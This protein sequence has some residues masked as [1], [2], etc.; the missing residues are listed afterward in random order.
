MYRTRQPCR[1]LGELPGVEV[2]SG[3]LLAPA[4]HA[5]LL[6][7]D[8]LV[9]CDVVDADLLPVVEARRAAGRLTVYEVND[10]FLAP[11]PWNP[12]AYLARNLLSRSL[13]SQTAAR[14]D[15]V[16]FSG[17][18]LATEFARLHPRRVV[19]ENQLWAV[20]PLRPRTVKD[21]LWLGWGGS[22]GHLE[23]MR[24]VMPALR[25]ALSRHP[26]LGLAIMGA[27]ELAPLL[28]GLPPGRTRYRPGGSLEEY[29]A[30]L[31]GLDLGV[32]PLLDTDF[33]RGRSDVKFLE[34][35]VRGVP[36]LCSDLPPYQTSVISG[37]TGFR[38]ATLDEL[39]AQI[40]RLVADAELR[41]RVGAAAHRYVASARRERARI[42]RRVEIYA[43]WADDRAVPDPLPG[44]A[45]WIGGRAA[46]AGSRYG[47]LE[48]SAEAVLREGLMLARDGRHEE[49]ATRYR[50]AA[51]RE[52][53]FYLPWLLLGSGDGPDGLEALE[54][55]RA[56]APNAPSVA[57]QRGVRLE[58]AG[59]IDEARA[60]FAE[61]AARAPALGAPEERLGL[62]AHAA[63]DET[64]AINHFQRAFA[65][66]PYFAAPAVRLASAALASGDRARAMRTLEE[67]LAH[68]PKL[69]LLHMM[70]GRAHVEAEQWREARLH[71]ERA[72]PEADP[73][74]PVLALLAKTHLAL[75]NSAVAN[76]LV[77][78]LRRLRAA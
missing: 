8:L 60:A 69:S 56:L 12:T 6:V 70:L 1:A 5:R 41:A 27:A 7:A 63:G 10:H 22:L 54:R 65:A 51:A 17:E 62:L 24:W 18:A 36:A 39:G 3:S 11:Q 35:A 66:N 40:D 9:L 2:A 25:A 29:E 19:F 68:D 53:G 21:R 4:V 64:A 48:G 61:A 33:N 42:G 76:A 45:D 13:S 16:Q 14:A 44:G 72:L 23:D 58:A 32:C 50:A 26:Q 75:G 38:F 55:A 46:F 59:R 77:A 57:F 71:L 78:E 37:E 49:A 20:P 34:L 28:D 74:Q 43:A 30:F 47:A 15:A 67:A 73:P 52:P 31:D